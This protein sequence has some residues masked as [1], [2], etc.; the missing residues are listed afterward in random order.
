[1]KT[2]TFD[3]K[4]LEKLKPL[5]PSGAMGGG[6]YYGADSTEDVISSKQ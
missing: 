4:S 2:E 6:P 1:L 3:K 5:Q